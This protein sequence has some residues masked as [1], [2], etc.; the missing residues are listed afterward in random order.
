MSPN[1]Q[2]SLIWF[3][4][5]HAKE[6][7]ERF[8]KYLKEQFQ[9]SMGKDE[10]AHQKFLDERIERYLDAIFCLYIYITHHVVGDLL[11]R[12]GR[13]LQFLDV[14]VKGLGY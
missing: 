9:T 12:R 11:L 3:A 8:D 14:K 6:Q 10:N 4:K 7:K 5:E 2:K 1:T 13:S